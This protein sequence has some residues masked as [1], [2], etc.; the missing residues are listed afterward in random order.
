MRKL[1]LL[2]LVLLPSMALASEME[3]RQFLDPDLRGLWMVHAVSQDG[4]KTIEEASEP[5]AI[6]RASATSIHFAG[7]SPILI[8]KVIFVK[9]RNALIV[10]LENGNMLICNR[11][12]GTRFV[13][14][15]FM[16]DL[17]DTFKE[18][19]RMLITVH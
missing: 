1:L 15:Q 9:D 4:G 13:M 10:R 12:T 7:K 19:G 3:E 2:V 8:D 18:I 17:G 14:V 11:D 6:L 16:Q 5:S